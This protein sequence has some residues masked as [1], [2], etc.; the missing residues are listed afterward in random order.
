MARPEYR[1]APRCHAGHDCSHD[2]PERQT[3]HPPARLR[4][5]PGAAGGDRGDG[6]PGARG[7]LPAHRHRADVPNEEGVGEAIA[8][9]GI[10]RDELY[11]TSK[12]NNGFH[13]PDDARRAFDETLSS[14]AWTGSTCSSSTG[15]CPRCTTATT[16][17]RGRPWPS[18][19]RTAAP[20]SIG[21]SNFQPAHLR[22]DRRR[23]RRRPGG[24]PDRGAP[25]LHQR[26]RP[27]GLDRHGVAVEAWSPIAQ[28]KVL[29]DEVI[30]KIAADYGKTAVAGHPAL[31]RRARR[32]R[33]PQV[34]ERRSGCAEN[35]EIFDFSLT[36]DEVAQISALDR[37]E[38]G[39][40][41][42]NPDTFDYIP[43]LTLR[44][45]AGGA[46]GS[47]RPEPPRRLDVEGPAP[48]LQQVRELGRSAVRSGR[49]SSRCSLARC[50][51]NGSSISS[52]PAS[53]SAI[54]PPAGVAVADPPGHPALLHA[55]VHA[56]WSPRP[57]RPSS[58]AA[59]SPGV[60]SYGAPARRSVASTS[61]SPS[62]SPDSAY[63]G[64]PARRCSASASRCSRP[65]TPIGDGSRSGRS[66]APLRHDPADV[67]EISLHP[68]NIPSEEDI[69]SLPWKLF[70][71]ASSSSRW[72]PPPRGARRTSSPSSFL[73]PDRPLFAATVRALPVGLV[74]LALRRQLPPRHLVVAGGRRWA[75]Q[76]R[77]V[78]PAD[79]PGGLPPARRPGRH[80]A[81][82]VA[83]RRDGA[84]LAR[85][86]RA[87][88]AGPGRRGPGRRASGVA[89]LVLRSP[90]H[91]DALGLAGGIR[92]GPGLRARLR[93]RQALAGPGRHLTLVSWQ[94]VV[95][96]LL[97]LPVG[98]ARRG[99]AARA[100]P[101][102]RRRLPV[103]R[104]GG[105]RR[106][107]TTAGSAASP[108]CPPA[109]S[110]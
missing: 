14:S 56:A 7:R 11:V 69:M 40:T 62:P 88:R 53:V 100:R 102:G 16:C 85:A 5:L 110:R 107:R 20:R 35:F 9:S 109:P 105:H 108:G 58:H 34:D 8:A 1:A 64:R 78:L 60:S 77:A 33:L 106:S 42:P 97:L 75:S 101:A 18:S 29:D 87:P 30:T 54:T 44:V 92:L 32:H 17:R 83:A 3:D 13:R 2:H 50:A 103:A 4:R 79:L 26:G 67:I 95:G 71:G 31:A 72:S 66:R 37:G 76:H 21:V 22:P 27:R 63:T 81:G 49:P 25:L 93:A 80:R 55:A 46:R 73:P 99:R 24:E 43:R 28:G 39:R 19:S 51:S 68:S 96:G 57:R 104:R 89:L 36:H 84:G 15:R 45:R 6:D 70:A 23:D 94:L 90:G 41:G 74:L 10:A 91:V 52:L 65:I 59:S 86:R 12:L 48:H 47:A 61:N 98:A 82:R 38:D